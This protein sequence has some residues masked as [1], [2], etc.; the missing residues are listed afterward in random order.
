MNT[1]V[2][3]LQQI[4]FEAA[5][6][7][8]LKPVISIYKNIRANTFGYHSSQETASVAH[9][10]LPLVVARYGKKV[11]GFASANINSAN[12]VEINCF[13]L[14]EYEEQEII[15]TLKQRAINVFNSSYN[16]D[17]QQNTRLK[18]SIKVLN[19][20]LEKCNQTH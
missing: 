19:N 2:N 14:Q 7:S 15:Q 12:Q 10:G 1:P 18:T 13:N 4:K 8:E 17:D 5:Y 3:K 20:W 6:L 11:I 9:F 16:Q